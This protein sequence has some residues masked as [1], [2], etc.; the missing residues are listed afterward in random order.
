MY[1][2]LKTLDDR[3]TFE[4]QVSMLP[5]HTQ[6]PTANHWVILRLLRV[7]AANYGIADLTNAQLADYQ[8]SITYLQKTVGPLGFAEMINKLNKEEKGAKHE[9]VS[10]RRKG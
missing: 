2:R 7:I 9:R 5:T 1:E 4:V 10:R 6:E 8:R 3:I